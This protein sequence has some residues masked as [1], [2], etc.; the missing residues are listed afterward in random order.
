MLGLLVCCIPLNC[1]LNLH[2]QAVHVWWN[3]HCLKRLIDL[4]RRL[5]FLFV[6]FEVNGGFFRIDTKAQVGMARHGP[7][8][9]LFDG[10][11]WGPRLQSGIASNNIIHYI[12]TGALS[13]ILVHLFLEPSSERI[14]I[15]AHVNQGQVVCLAG[16]VEFLDVQAQ[17]SIEDH[18]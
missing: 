15:F 10:L 12:S 3:N 5:K 18:F 11:L 6:I 8:I 2:L 16:F 7:L 9:H 14:V 4:S 17:V 13:E 1:L